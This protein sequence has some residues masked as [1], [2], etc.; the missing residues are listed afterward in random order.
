MA[1]FTKFRIKQLKSNQNNKQKTKL[2]VKQLI[3][4]ILHATRPQSNELTK[5]QKKKKKKK[6]EHQN[7]QK[8]SHFLPSMVL[9]L[10]PFGKTIKSINQKQR[11]WIQ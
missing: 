6:N 2:Y 11:Q 3:N 7:F 4:H 5:K 1:H 9:L 8:F 10:E